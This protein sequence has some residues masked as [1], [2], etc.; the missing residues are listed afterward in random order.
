V[1]PFDGLGEQFEGRRHGGSFKAGCVSL[2]VGS[3]HGSLA[4]APPI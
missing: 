1:D 3:A 2:I 4:L